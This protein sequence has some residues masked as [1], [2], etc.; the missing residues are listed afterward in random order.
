MIDPATTSIVLSDQVLLRPVE[1]TGVMLDLQTERY[2]GL[3]EVAL[4][5]V[6]TAQS[7]PDL[8]A[9]VSELGKIY[10]ADVAEIESDLLE[11]MTDLRDRGLVELVTNQ[12]D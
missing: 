2:I 1:D 5:M 12:Q 8:A 11:L 3:D 9:A 6:Q 4:Q 7:C 10:D